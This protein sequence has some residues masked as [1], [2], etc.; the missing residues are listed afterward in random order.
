M[1]TLVKL[2]SE[3]AGWHL[4]LKISHM[5]NLFNMLLIYALFIHLNNEIFNT[6]CIYNRLCLFFMVLYWSVSPIP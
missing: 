1:F 5:S 4:D 3:N 6:I 2:N